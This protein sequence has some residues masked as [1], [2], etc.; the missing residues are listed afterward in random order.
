MTNE[1]IITEV[2]KQ[3]TCRLDWSND[4]TS[5]TSNQEFDTNK[6]LTPL[7]LI[8]SPPQLGSGSRV[9]SDL[10]LWKLIIEWRVQILANDLYL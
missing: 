6:Y 7:I 1:F 9:T 5:V 3:E 4:Y 10:A 2:D 8:R